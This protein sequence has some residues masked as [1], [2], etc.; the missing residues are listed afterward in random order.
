MNYTRDLYEV[1]LLDRIEKIQSINEQY[2]LEN[3]SYL[4][5]S[6]G[7]DSTVVHYL[8]DIALPNNNIPRVYMNTGIEY[9]DMVKFIKEMATKDKR[10]KII[11]SG[12]NIRK[13]LREVGYPFKS[14]HHSQMLEIYQKNSGTIDKEIQNFEPTLEYVTNIPRTSKAVIC[15][16]KGVRGGDRT[17]KENLHSP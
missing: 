3:N 10:I 4:S 5:F 6:G 11:N 7:K 13:M 14:K 1:D 15:Y 12:V 8:L 9:T 16:I 17:C 2:D